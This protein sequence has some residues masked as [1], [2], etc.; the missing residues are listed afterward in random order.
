MWVFFVG[1]FCFVLEAPIQ[2]HTRCGGVVTVSQQAR[3]ENSLMNESTTTKT[4][5]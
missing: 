4:K 2:Q 1:L 3:G 5:L